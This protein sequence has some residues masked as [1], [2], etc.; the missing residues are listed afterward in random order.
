MGLPNVLVV[1]QGKGGVGKTSLAANLAGLIAA[2]GR[3]VLIVDL[4]QQA[5]LRREFGTEYDDGRALFTAVSNTSRPPITQ[6]VRERLDMVPG[7]PAVADL[8]F[9]M[10]GRLGAD[11][12]HT[13]TD[14]IANTLATVADDYD[15]VIVDTPP[16]ERVMVEAAMGAARW[17]VIPTAADEGS[18]DGLQLTAK[19]FVNARQVNPDLQLLGVVLFG[20]SAQSKTI[21][22]DT[23]RTIEGLIGSAGPV[24]AARIRH[25]AAPAVD[26]RRQ[27]LLI[28]ELEQRVA[29][30]KSHRLARLSGRG[31]DHASVDLRTR[32]AKG[33]GD[34]YWALTN[35]ILAAMK[36][37]LTGVSA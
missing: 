36:A 23:R 37:S 9:V 1:A 18:I 28:H 10:I 6:N 24:F 14:L 3:R 35:E 27:G 5:N 13:P 15:L 25:Q 7:G 32:D 26:A 19:R 16:G 8:V 2:A 34:D 12:G 31:Q 20:I 11:G 22:R 33:L 29:D 17:L 30:A 21:E 4:D